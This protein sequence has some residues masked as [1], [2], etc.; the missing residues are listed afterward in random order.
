MFITLGLYLHSLTVGTHVLLA[1]E[2]R[3]PVHILRS[4]CL[5]FT[6]PLSPLASKPESHLA[7]LTNDTGTDRGKKHA[8][9]RA[10]NSQ[11]DQ[12]HDKNTGSDSSS[13]PNATWIPDTEKATRTPV[14][15]LDEDPEP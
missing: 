15:N 12:L 10:P 6:L 14:L 11:H 2:A 4:S 13:S 5:I 7:S 1:L 9:K 3:L 8:H